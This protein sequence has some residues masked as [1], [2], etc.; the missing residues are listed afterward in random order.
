MRNEDIISSS[1]LSGVWEE[2]QLPLEKAEDNVVSSK[3]S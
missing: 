2:T 3:A 1:S